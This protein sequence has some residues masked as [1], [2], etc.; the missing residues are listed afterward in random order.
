MKKLLSSFLLVI[1]LAGCGENAIQQV[2]TCPSDYP[3]CDT[4][5]QQ[6]PMTPAEIAYHQQQNDMDAAVLDAIILQDMM[7]RNCWS[8]YGPTYYSRYGY[9]SSYTPAQRAVVIQKNTTVINNNKTVIQQASAKTPST[10][11]AVSAPK[12]V[13]APKPAPKPAAPRINTSAGTSR[14]AGGGV[15]GGS[16]FRSTSHK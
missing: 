3:Q 5:V 14:P 1:V 4:T 9:Y 7:W 16:S 6:P 2:S 8:C 10:V 13:T 11:K 12:P 15:G